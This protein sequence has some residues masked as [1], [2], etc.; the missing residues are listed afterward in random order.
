MAIKKQ[1]IIENYPLPVYNYR[2]VINGNEEMSFSEVTGLEVLYK[3][4]VYK[5]GFSHVT[6]LTGLH[7][8]RGQREPIRLNLKKGVVK[9]SSYLYD[10]F[11]SGRKRNIKIDLC[12]ENAIPLVSWEIERA[13]PLKLDAPSFNASTSD[14]AIEHLGLIAHDLKITYHE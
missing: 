5:Q 2:V 12:D 9:K 7:I 10:W 13:L 6:G 14:V 8:I 1:E 3:E 11:K 4:V